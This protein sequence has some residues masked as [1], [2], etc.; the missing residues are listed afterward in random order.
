MGLSVMMVG[1]AL[2]ERRRLER[3]LAAA[4]TRAELA[5]EEAQVARQAAEEASRA[6]SMFLANMSHELRTPLNAVIGFSQTMQEE[7][8]GPLGN[9]KYSEYAG[10]ISKA[11]GHLLDL[12]NDIL[13]MSRIEAGKYDLRCE[14]VDAAALLHECVRLVEDSAESAGL[15]LNVYVEPGTALQADR[16]ALKQILLNLLSNA[17][18]FT[19]KDGHIE[20]RA[21]RGADGVTLSVRDSGVGIPAG[22][23]ARAGNPFTQF[24]QSSGRQG[25]GLGLALV[26][27]LVQLHGGSLNIESKEGA[28]TCVTVTIPATAATRAAA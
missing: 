9:A 17:V 4:I 2:E 8:F 27:S 28:G 13:D 23:L 20:A 12:I 26:R 14:P 19:P 1:A 16:R 18:K 22:Q 11:G 10:L 3:G 21:W 6:K 15:S 24:H 25:T 5:R 7:V